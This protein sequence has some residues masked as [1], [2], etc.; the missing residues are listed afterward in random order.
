M[1]GDLGG[2]GG[3]RGRVMSMSTASCTYV[4]WY[5]YDPQV[6]WEEF[7]T[8]CVRNCAKLV[9]CKS[10]TGRHE[11]CKSLSDRCVQNTVQ[12]VCITSCRAHAE[13]LAT[14]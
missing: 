14:V 6:G 11:P 5:L 8:L 9:C 10:Q 1:G 12:V 13:M 3:D 2:G 4:L 7:V